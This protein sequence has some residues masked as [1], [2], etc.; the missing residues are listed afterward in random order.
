[1]LL[2]PAAL[3]A[4]VAQILEA[5]FQPA[6]HA[7]GDRAVA[8]VIGAFEAA[9]D[10]DRVRALRPRVEHLQLVRPGLPSRLAAVGGVA[11]MQPTHATSDGPWVPTRLGA[12]SE[13]LQGAYA[14][15][16]V[17]RAGVPLAFGSDFPIESPDPRLGLYAAEAR[18]PA[19]V[20]AA[21]LPEERI[22]REEALR[23][24][25]VGAAHAAFA[26][27]RRGMIREGLDADL[28][29]FGADVAA[30]PAEALPTL[31]VTHTIVAGRVVHE[32]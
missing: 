21:F 32:R 18:R 28:T 1:L 23:A 4:R 25:T 29:A 24:F 19:G 6:V 17:L 14:W 31:S 20:A 7:I 2:E 26:E 3:A 16:T 11:S 27:R 15:R 12:G 13:R 22:T 9:G 8:E 5:G 10:A 30:V